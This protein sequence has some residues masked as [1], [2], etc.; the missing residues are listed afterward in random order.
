M[1]IKCNS[2]KSAVERI[3]KYHINH[4]I[5]FNIVIQINKIQVEI[6]NIIE[7]GKK[8]RINSIK[9]IYIGYMLKI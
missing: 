6:V 5:I 4:A 8:L 9:E 1:Q 2:D 7:Y 3:L